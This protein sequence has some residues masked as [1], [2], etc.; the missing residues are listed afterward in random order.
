M[1]SR[2]MILPDFMKEDTSLRFTRCYSLRYPFLGLY[3][4]FDYGIN[5]FI[6]L[7]TLY[8]NLHVWGN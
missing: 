1:S 4:T 6:N 5:V 2:F 3:V 8:I 7:F